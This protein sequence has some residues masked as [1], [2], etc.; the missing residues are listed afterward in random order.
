MFD[1]TDAACATAP[2]EI[3]FPEGKNKQA[4]EYAA[5]VICASCPIQ[6]ECLAHAITNNEL[7][8]WGGKTEEER[9]HIRL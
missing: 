2:L 5:K 8:V 1:M 3:F 9:K 6:Q 4:K 7:G